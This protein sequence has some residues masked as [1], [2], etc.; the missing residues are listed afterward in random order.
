MNDTFRFLQKRYT[1]LILPAAESYLIMLVVRFL[2][3]PIMLMI[4]FPA[5]LIPASTGRGSMIFIIVLMIAIYIIAMI[6]GAFAMGIMLGGTVRSVD[7]I[8]NYEKCNFGDVFKYGW[9]HKWELFT[10]HLLNY[11]LIFLIFIAILGGFIGLGILI[12]RSSLIA[13]LMFLI[14]GVMIG[15]FSLYFMM[16]LMYLPFIVRHKRGIKGTENIIMA[17]KEFFSEPITYGMIGFLYMILIL[18][19]SMVPLLNI[20]VALAL[21]VAFISTLLI[22]YDEK[23]MIPVMPHP[24]K[25]PIYQRYDPRPHYQQ[26]PR[27]D[28]YPGN[29]QY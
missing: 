6:I 16:S 1:D 28:Q 15:P 23:Y 12:M 25:D 20:I 17:W 14:F 8:R 10:I 9:K 2:M 19:L 18:V 21:H 13:G 22:H 7:K 26:Y 27:V 11:F 5:L 3:I 29:R 24:I 4:I